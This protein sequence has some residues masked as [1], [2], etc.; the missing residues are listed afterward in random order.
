[1]AKRASL[2]TFAPTHADG[3]HVERS[4]ISPTDV[5]AQPIAGKKKYPHVTVYLPADVV[6]TL[7]LLAIDSET[8]V[9]D[10]CAEAVTEWLRQKGHVRGETFK[11]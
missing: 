3:A 9:S 5:P 6:R 8:R 4:T 7:K 11:A 2:S 1:M 10:L